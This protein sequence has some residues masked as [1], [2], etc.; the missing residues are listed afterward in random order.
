[1][2]E[3]ES[4]DRKDSI[5]RAH[6]E[7]PNTSCD[8]VTK[9]VGSS[10]DSLSGDRDI[11]TPDSI[12]SRISD[13]DSVN[14][15]GETEV[16]TNGKVLSS[17]IIAGGQDIN[18][19]TDSD[20]Q[21]KN[22]IELLCRLF[23]HMKKSVLQLI[24]QGC[25][26]DTTQAIE[27]VLNN[28]S[29]TSSQISLAKHPATIVPQQPYLHSAY[30]SA[31]PSATNGFKSAFSPISSLNSHTLGAL[32]YPYPPTTRGIPF[33]LPYG[34][35]VFPG[36]ANIGYNY[37]AMAAAAVSVNGGT[38]PPTASFNFSPYGNLYA[39]SSPDK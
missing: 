4:H 10:C 38:K 19:V 6:E 16:T 34:P 5:W 29:Q 13:P 3:S 7:T 37:N 12:H 24:L 11:H 9:D 15:M 28:H 8:D 23:P 17:S 27:Q 21:S 31:T 22:N 33:G 39:G 32:R 1:M 2:K 36:L 18:T 30:L 25:Q 26:G 35:N 14:K 20:G